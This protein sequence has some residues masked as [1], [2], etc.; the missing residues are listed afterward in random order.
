MT[1]PYESYERT[2]YKSLLAL[3][4]RL[5]I[6][7]AG[8]ETAMRGRFGD[9]IAMMALLDAVLA[10]CTLLPDADASYQAETLNSAPPA[11]AV[12]DVPGVD[13]SAY[14]PTAPDAT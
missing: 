2:G 14:E 4:R 1:N 13:P 5:C 12:E 9:N 6:L 11:D 3:A 7:V 10:I 8:L